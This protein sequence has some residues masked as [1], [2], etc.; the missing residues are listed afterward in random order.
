VQNIAPNEDAKAASR[1]RNEGTRKSVIGREEGDHVLDTAERRNSSRKRKYDIAVRHQGARE[2]GKTA[3]KKPQQKIAR[4]LTG[5]HGVWTMR[6]LVAG[7]AFD[8]RGWGEVIALA[9][10]AGGLGLDDHPRRKKNLKGGAE[11]SQHE[12]HGR[13]GDV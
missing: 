3:E 9:M 13:Q 4:E 11:R 6:A 8:E 10:K 2:H 12:A 7:D 5:D 1:A